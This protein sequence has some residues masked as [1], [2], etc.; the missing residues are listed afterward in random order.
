MHA[1]YKGTLITLLPSLQALGKHGDAL[2]LMDGCL[3]AAIDEA[4]KLTHDESSAASNDLSKGGGQSDG[5]RSAVAPGAAGG[6]VRGSASGSNSHVQVGYGLF[7]DLLQRKADYLHGIGR[8]DQETA[9]QAEVAVQLHDAEHRE[10]QSQAEA[11]A[12]V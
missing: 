6:A 7:I 4:Q 9:D 2:R 1:E 12:S 8:L 5:I 11:E 3:T 10:P